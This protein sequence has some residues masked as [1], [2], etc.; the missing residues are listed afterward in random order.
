MLA[1][2]D[3]A[4]AKLVFG[5]MYDHCSCHLLGTVCLTQML[6]MHLPLLL[7]LT[8]RPALRTAGLFLMC[9]LHCLVHLPE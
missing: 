6:L 1:V 2:V 5:S 8:A 7:W 4:W 3:L 9:L